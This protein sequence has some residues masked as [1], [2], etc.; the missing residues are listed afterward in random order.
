MFGYLVWNSA[1]SASRTLPSGPVRPFQ[2]VSVTFPVGTATSPAAAGFA[3]VLAAG[4]V[5]PAGWAAGAAGLLSFGLVSAGFAGA[6][7]AAGVLLDPPPH[8]WSSPLAA[9]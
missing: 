9:N 6:L 7:V 3:S 1:T 5:V 8:A 4:A 2:K